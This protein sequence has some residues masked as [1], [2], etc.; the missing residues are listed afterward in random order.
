MYNTKKQKKSAK[1]KI[2]MY[3]SSNWYSLSDA[4]TSYSYRKERA[5]DYCVH[6]MIEYNG[7]RL[8]VISRN[9]NF[10]TAGFTFFDSETGE[11]MFYYITANYDC[12]VPYTL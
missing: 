6:T 3:D 2:P 8:K 11:P 1:A 10:F 9:T 7:I 12:I 5:W 4:Y